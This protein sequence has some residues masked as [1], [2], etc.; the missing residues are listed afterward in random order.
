MGRCPS[1]QSLLLF[2]WE[3]P[4]CSRAGCSPGPR[5]LKFTVR[6]GGRPF[7]MLAEGEVSFSWNPEINAHCARAPLGQPRRGRTRRRFPANIPSVSDGADFSAGFVGA[8]GEGVRISCL[9]AK[10]REAPEAR[11]PSAPSPR[12]CSSPWAAGAGQRGLLP[13]LPWP[14]RPRAGSSVSS[15]L[16]AA[17]NRLLGRVLKN[18]GGIPI[19]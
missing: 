6:D 12:A 14:P 7:M 2:L 4:L 1:F 13:L 9:I 15:P 17:A 19:T 3:A 8:P 10:T 11:P 16:P 18:R 5:P